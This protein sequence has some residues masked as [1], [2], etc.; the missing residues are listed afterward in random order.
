MAELHPDER[1][2]VSPQRCE[3]RQVEVLWI[4]EGDLELDKR[5]GV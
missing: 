3:N 1:V 4:F 2:D 5:F